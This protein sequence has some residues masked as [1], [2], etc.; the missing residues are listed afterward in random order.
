MSTVDPAANLPREASSAASS[1]EQD[2]R[3]AWDRIARGYDR[4]NTETQLALGTQAVGRVELRSGMRFLDVAAGSGA[5]GIPAA[6]LGARVLAVDQS[7]MML[8][9]L[10]A[11][12]QREGL[13]VETRVMDG[14]ALDLEDASFDIAGSQFGVMLFHDMPRGIREMKRVL[15]PG[16]RV[17]IVAYGDP[18]RIDFLSFFVEVVRALRPSFSGPPVDPPPLAFQLQDAARLAN[19]LASAGLAEIRVDTITEATEFRSG[20]G[21]WDWILC[22]NPIVEDVLCSLQ[23]SRDERAT[24]ERRAGEAFREHAGHGGVARLVNPVNIAVATRPAPR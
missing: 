11:R 18:G 22:S 20:K 1:A 19:E 13:E 6:R 16:G 17:L 3:P 21:L 4:T 15:R 24:L 14:H 7:P 12:A 2:T 5:L 9:L 8:E 10:R 23:I